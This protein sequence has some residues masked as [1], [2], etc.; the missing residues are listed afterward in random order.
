MEQAKPSDKEVPDALA[1][2]K[3]F[4]EAEKQPNLEKLLG[5]QAAA[6]EATAT[7]QA[8]RAGSSPADAAP[9]EAL[10]KEFAALQEAEAKLKTVRRLPRLAAASSQTPL[11]WPD[12][13]W[14]PLPPRLMRPP[15]WQHAETEI[16][17]YLEPTKG[18][19]PRR[20]N[21]K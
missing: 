18:N 16:K 3:A 14:L 6:N 9:V 8:Q 12:H 13:P 19:Q 21:K 5:C 7:R 20:G 17:E 4:G 11:D 15:P 2:L 10:A 1:S